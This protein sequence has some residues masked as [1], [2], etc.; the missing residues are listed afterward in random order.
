MATPHPGFTLWLTGMSL[1]GKSTIARY[2]AERFRVLGR[3]VEL[4]DG[5]DVHDLFAKGLQ[6]NKDDR[7]LYVRRIGFVSRAV[8]RSGGVAIVPTISP[9]RDARDQ[10]R[11]ETPKFV[12]VFVDCP[13]DELIKRDTTGRYKKAMAGEL[14]N[15]IGITDGYEPPKLAEVVIQSNVEPVAQA[16]QRIFQMLLDLGL[17]QPDDVKLMAGAKLTK[18]AGKKARDKELEEGKSPA[19]EIKV[20]VLKPGQKLSEKLAPPKPAKPAPKAEKAPE[21]APAKAEKKAEKPAEKKPAAKAEKAP[22]KAEKPAAKVEKKPAAK[23]A[24]GKH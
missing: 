12:E 11:R 21:K 3:Q 24:K 13:I 17:L 23:P 9:Y 1:A 10:V 18:G 16:A 20:G 2:V 22:A 4:L 14:T 5:P 15:F 6:E 8:T 19:K 7:N